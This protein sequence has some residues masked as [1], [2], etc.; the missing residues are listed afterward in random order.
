VPDPWGGARSA[1]ERAL[2][3]I[4]AGCKGLLKHVTMEAA[5]GNGGSGGSGGGGGR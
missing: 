1:Y 5:K 4:E 2:D 3:L